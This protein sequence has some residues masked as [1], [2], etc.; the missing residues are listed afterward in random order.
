[1]QQ[2]QPLG[3]DI[4]DEK[5]DARRVTTRTG[6]V[7]TRSNLTGS[8]PTPKTIGIVVVAALAA[9]AAGLLPGVAMTATRRRTKSV[10][11]DGRRSYFPPNQ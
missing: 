11:S 2:P 8:A 5:I 1:V 6:K 4:R 9:S 3:R 10:M 7:V